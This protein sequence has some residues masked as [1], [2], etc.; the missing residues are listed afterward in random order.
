M[1]RLAIKM[2][3]NDRLKYLG[4]LIGLAFAATLIT[5]QASIFMGYT[6]RMWAFFGDMP[7]TDV[8]VMDREM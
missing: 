7:H 5:Q 1:I 6:Q 8:W 3:V 2:I 4:L